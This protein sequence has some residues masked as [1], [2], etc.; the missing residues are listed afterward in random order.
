M[1]LWEK[2]RDRETERGEVKEKRRVEVTIGTSGALDT[3][4][5]IAIWGYGNFC[6]AYT[7]PSPLPPSKSYTES[8]QAKNSCIFDLFICLFGWLVFIHLLYCLNSWVNKVAFFDSSILFVLANTH[9]FYYQ[10][11]AQSFD[12]RTKKAAAPFNIHA[13]CV[14]LQFVFFLKLNDVIFCTCF[15]LHW[16][17]SYLQKYTRTHTHITQWRKNKHTCTRSRQARTNCRRCSKDS[18]IVSSYSICD[19]PSSLFCCCC[20]SLSLSHSNYYCTITVVRLLVCFTYTFVH[21]LISLFCSFPTSVIVDVN[22]VV[23]VVAVVGVLSWHLP[24]Y[25][26]YTVHI[27]RPFVVIV[28]C[29]LLSKLSIKIFVVVVVC[30]NTDFILIHCTWC[31]RSFVRACV[32]MCICSIL[33][34]LFV[35]HVHLF[36]DLWLHTDISSSFVSPCEYIEKRRRINSNQINKINDSVCVLFWSSICCAFNN[37]SFVGFSISPRYVWEWVCVLLLGLYSMS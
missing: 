21:L 27:E 35:I 8:L 12:T 15:D 26:C 37:F 1:K 25:G 23:V 24:S 29:V 34:F 5:K 33:F 7:P 11:I 19:N 3:A 28:V 36:C 14:W 20:C 2:Q 4:N 30:V 10:N 16:I 22:V 32:R 17:Y 31:V 6:H 18:N 13:N 9:A